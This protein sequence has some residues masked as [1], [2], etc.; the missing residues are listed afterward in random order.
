MQ[1]HPGTRQALGDFY[2]E[3]R[4]MITGGLGFIGWNLA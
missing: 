1:D 2:H 4:V 3:R